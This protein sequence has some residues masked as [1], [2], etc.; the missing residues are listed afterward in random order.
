MS[1]PIAPSATNRTQ[2]LGGVAAAVGIAA[3]STVLAGLL[4][5]GTLGLEISPLS[6]IMLAIVLGAILC[7]LNW[8]PA[9]W[10]SGLKFCTKA[11]LQTGIVFLGFRLSLTAAGTIGL[12]ALPLVLTCIATALLVV[13]VAGRLMGLPIRLT[14]LIAIGTSICGCTAIVAMAPLIRARDEEVSYGIAVVA[15]FGMVA[16]LVYPWLAQGLFSARP[17]LA[18]YFLGTSIHDTAQVA[19]AALIYQQ[20]FLAPEA[21]NVATVTKLVRNLMMVA[22]IPLVALMFRQASSAG[23]KSFN[24]LSGLVPPFILA[25]IAMCALRSVG[26]GA[27][28]DGSNALGIFNP[29]RWQQLT[30]S[31]G[32]AAK[33]LLATAMAAVGLTTR[34]DVLSRLGL[35]PFLL[36]LTAAMAV[37]GASLI[38]LIS[39]VS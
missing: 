10:Q 6:P 13:T 20:Q 19:G 30:D 21:L 25:F 3:V 39:V 16:M 32:T 5:G 22:L 27:I 23:D 36:G 38:Y 26:D 14:G 7:N 35:K 4:G 1:K 28:S 33:W 12:T 8:V 29:E 24:S 31:L 11:V 15:I 2:W 34:L 18:G 17:D 9:S 37:G